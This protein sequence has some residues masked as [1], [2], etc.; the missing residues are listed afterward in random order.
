[1]QAYHSALTLDDEVSYSMHLLE[2]LLYSQIP[3]IKYIWA[4]K[5]NFSKCIYIATKYLAF[6]DGIMN[7]ICKFLCW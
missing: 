3:K 7:L 6:C 5:W 2:I 1:M 4:S